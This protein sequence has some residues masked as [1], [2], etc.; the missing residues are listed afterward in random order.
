[1]KLTE[2]TDKKKTGFDGEEYAAEYLV[3]KGY[4]ILDRNHQSGRVELDIVARKDNWLVFVEV[5]TRFG[6]FAY[7]E[8]AVGKQKQRNLQVAAEIY[9]D[10]RNIDAQARFD[11]VAIVIGKG[12]P[13][14]EHFEDAFYP[15]K[16]Y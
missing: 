12:R 7:P 15:F 10:K 9:M 11:I 13:Q 3:S 4:I 6:D 2:T 1:M 5:K 8:R 14:V 16:T